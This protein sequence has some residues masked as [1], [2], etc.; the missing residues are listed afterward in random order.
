MPFDASSVQRLEYRPWRW[1]TP[2]AGD[3][4][5]GV[6]EDIPGGGVFILLS[7]KL[8]EQLKQNLTAAERNELQT[9]VYPVTQAQAATW[10]VPVWA[11]ET[12]AVYLRIPAAVW[13]NPT[14]TP[15]AKVKR[16][17]QWLWREAS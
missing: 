2:P 17:F 8:V 10:H 11:G 14:G 16:F 15:P 5:G 7:P 13:N 4:T 9:Y 3:G 6:K 12:N 1:T